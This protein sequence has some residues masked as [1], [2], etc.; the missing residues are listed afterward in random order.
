MLREVGNRDAEA[1][2]RFLDRHHGDM[3][4]TMLR[5]AIER[6]PAPK[7]RAYLAASPGGASA[8]AAR[9]RPARA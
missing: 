8:R 7:R 1:A 9:R 4:R 2:A 5:C 6:L 3:P